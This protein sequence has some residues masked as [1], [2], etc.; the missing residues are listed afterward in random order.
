MIEPLVD[1]A[2]I[3]EIEGSIG[4]MM[5]LWLEGMFNLGIQTIP[6]GI[7]ISGV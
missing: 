7:Q 3:K 2:I 4:E 1:G 5:V 6:Q